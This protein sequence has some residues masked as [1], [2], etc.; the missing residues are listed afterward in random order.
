MQLKQF[1]LSIRQSFSPSEAQQIL[2]ALRQD[3]LI[4][5]Q[6][7]DELFRERFVEFAQKDPKMWGSVNAAILSLDSEFETKTLAK[8]PKMALTVQIKQ[9]S[10]EEVEEARHGLQQTIP[11]RSAVLTAFGL[12]EHFRIAGNWDAVVSELSIPASRS[13]TGGWKT[14]F[15]CLSGMVEDW[16]SVQD[17][18][19]RR[20]PVTFYVPIMAHVILST[21]AAQDE[22]IK[23]FVDFLSLL[24]LDAQAA[25]V[26][27]LFECGEPIFSSNV[28]RQLSESKD[29][30]FFLSK[31][32]ERISLDDVLVDAN[33]MQHLA[34][35]H[36][37]SGNL[38]ISQQLV[39]KS[40]QFLQYRNA[41]LK[42]QEIERTLPDLTLEAANAFLE[43]SFSGLPENETIQEELILAVGN[44]P[45]GTVWIDQAPEDSSSAWVQFCKARRYLEA[46]DR[47][48]AEE[49]AQKALCQLFDQIASGKNVLERQ[50]LSNWNPLETVDFLKTLEMEDQALQ[51]TET[52]LY[53]RPNDLLLIERLGRIRENQKEETERLELAQMEALL[54]PK[55]LTRH[56][57]LADLWESGEDWGNAYVERHEIL[58]LSENPPETDRVAFAQSA[59][60]TQNYDEAMEACDSVLAQNQN[61]GFANLLMGKAVMETGNPASAISYLSNATLLIP[62]EASGWMLLAKA[63][64]AEEQ[65]RRAQETLQTAIL[66]APESVDINYALGESYRKSG[67]LSEALPYLKKA[68]SL[69]PGSF[70]VAL[71]LAETLKALGYLKEAEGFIREA[72]KKWPRN[73][74]LAYLE[75]ET[76]L[77][78]G[79]DESALPALEVSVS[80]DAPPLARLMVYVKTLLQHKNP[81]LV[82]YPSLDRARLSKA[83]SAIEK[84]LTITPTDLQS[85]IYL[86][87]VAGALGLL[88]EAF[89]HLKQ[90]L[91]APEANQP[92][93]KWRVQGD[94]GVVALK[95]DEIETALA[96]L[97]Q[98]VQDKPEM[99]DLQR[100]LADAYAQ[101]DLATEALQTAKVVLKM[102]PDDIQN[103]SWFADISIRLGKKEEA[104]NALRCATQL[105][106]DH[107]EYFI[108]L[109]R[110]EW[111]VGDFGSAR[112][113]LQVLVS[114]DCVTAD[115]LEQAAVLFHKLGDSR[116]SLAS[117]EQAIQLDSG[118]QTTLYVEIAYLNQ[119]V[120]RF[121]D[122]LKALQKALESETRQL[123]LYVFQSDLLTTL[124]RYDAA[125]AC[126]EHALKLKEEL[127]SGEDQ[128]AGQSHSTN[129]EKGI[130]P[131]VWI[132]ELEKL[133][134]IHIRFAGLLR[135][136]NDLSLALEHSVQAL[137]ICPESLELRYFAADVA[138]ALLRMEEAA[139]LA[140]IP[141]E[142]EYFVEDQEE[143]QKEE[144]EA[145]IALTCLRAEIAFT[146]GEEILAGRLIQKAIATAPENPRVIAAQSRLLARWG[147]FEMANEYFIRAVTNYQHETGSLKT[148]TQSRKT[149]QY[150]PLEGYYYR[151]QL[152]LSEAA[153]ELNRWQKAMQF[154][155]LYIREMP[156]EPRASL[157]L[158]K[159]Y[160]LQAEQKRICDEMNCVN[161]APSENVLEESQ[162]EKADA[163]LIEAD[164]IQKST[165][166][167]R[168]RLRHEVVFHLS[169]ENVRRMMEGS[170]HPEDLIQIVAALRWIGNNAGAIQ[171]A[172][173]S[174]DRPDLLL[175]LAMCYMQE[176]GD[177]SLEM[178]QK[179]VA[180]RPNNPLGHAVLAMIAGNRGMWVLALQSIETALSFWPDEPAWHAL[181]AE[182]VMHLNDFNNLLSHLEQAYELAPGR[183]EYAL[184]LGK[185]YLELE[186]Y[187]QA[188]EV[189][190]K[191]VQLNSKSADAWYQLACA[192]QQVGNLMKGMDCADRASSLDGQMVE[193]LL[194]SGEIALQLGRLN[195]ALGYAKNALRRD[196]NDQHAIQFLV[197]VLKEQGEWKKALRVIEKSLPS[198]EA[199][200]IALLLDRAR[201]VLELDGANAALPLLTEL[202]KMEK[203][204]PQVLHLLAKTQFE[205]GDLAASEQ[206]AQ[207]SLQSGPEESEMHL[208]LGQ[209]NLQTG[210]LDRAVHHL[211]EAI[212]I[213]PL[214]IEAYLELAKTYQKRREEEKALQIYQKAIKLSEKDHRP[215]YE[216]GLIL[217]ER[218]NYVEAETM[219]RY[220]S[221][222]AP[223]DINIRRQLGAIVALN[224]V[225]NAQEVRPLL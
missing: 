160:I 183:F 115:Y 10:L 112:Q 2:A 22:Q 213:A 75:A 153:L 125:V 197:A 18:L 107:P 53:A 201:L 11:L 121:E 56:R 209:I 166:V 27:Y 103:L 52:L 51:L 79:R 192:Y 59:V 214:K 98:S 116:L 36:E 35:L 218:K 193:P 127:T 152:W 117:L 28:A 128:L 199:P 30:E 14:V 155:E 123:Y 223:E 217:R 167:E 224:L 89:K 151:W 32:L 196:S 126:L 58:N 91:E 212:R 5:G 43:E 202:S 219:L 140:T 137:V 185:V 77:A 186:N 34:Y 66:T 62:E 169:L 24:T 174:S 210:H 37:K 176:D 101:A 88:D 29:L 171:V 222:M 129:Q 203:D 92:Q 161:H 20:T 76:L 215:Y 67:S 194:L 182:Y 148:E 69:N 8:T 81:L 108:Q 163:L 184:A 144:L 39:E 154:M 119:R 131:E 33:H 86:A 139:E 93:L 124:H 130:I 97:E 188:V 225:H 141:E 134:S 114:L 23:R 102:A 206:N 181:A 132:R 200:S 220:A 6:F 146:E 17:T 109:A 177:E 149:G 164:K 195:H 104:V 85:R 162:Y 78:S 145:W 31:T 122:A 173:R 207:M 40:K 55:D 106:A 4:W 113:T 45:A 170:T 63:Y 80:Q 65:P 168:W 158:A 96:A 198:I 15:T 47:S 90:V 191:A 187:S 54:S 94:L 38:D 68:A 138:G 13:A 42:I 180:S 208:L 12:R 7:L 118:D 25:G 3:A 142:H 178:A 60:A 216:A 157:L 46:E 83:L 172:K 111:Q 21:P 110:L 189:L 179:A 147:D 87:E 120:G 82:Y 26:R 50:F 41:G 9:A 1:L 99:I 100:F 84:I 159:I 133:S 105:A 165:E 16:L 48:R 72:R 136:R 70:S 71:D 156:Y 204:H 61:N 135:E 95:L 49:T 64:Q 57:K 205:L 19:V 73:T 143:I 175:Q 221:E 74:E 190:S 44:S 150:K 211:S